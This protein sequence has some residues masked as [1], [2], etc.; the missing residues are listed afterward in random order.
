MHGNKDF[1]KTELLDHVLQRFASMASDLVTVEG[2]DWRPP[3]HEPCGAV[4][5]FPPY[6]GSS[7]VGREK[8][9]GTIP[10]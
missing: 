1:D 8:R 3:P 5:R 10:C 9:T 4:E 7:A 6:G 2:S